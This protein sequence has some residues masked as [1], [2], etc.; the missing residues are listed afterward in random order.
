M[1]AI[2][3]RMTRPGIGLPN[4]QQTEED[5]R[6]KTQQQSDIGL[7]TGQ[8][9]EEERQKRWQEWHDANSSKPP[10]DHVVYEA[11]HGP[12][13]ANHPVV[14][15]EQQ[16]MAA[17]PTVNQY[18]QM[19]L[20][21]MNKH[22]IR[23][24]DA[25]DMLDK[26]GIQAPEGTILKPRPPLNSV[27]SAAEP[28]SLMR[29]LSSGGMNHSRSHARYEDYVRNERARANRLKKMKLLHGDVDTVLTEEEWLEDQGQRKPT[30]SE[31]LEAAL[32]AHKKNRERDREYEAAHGGR[33]WTED[34]LDRN[35][36]NARRQFRMRMA[37]K[38]AGQIA[39]NPSLLTDIMAEYDAGVTNKG[40]LTSGR[41]STHHL[42]G[43][44]GA[45]EM[46]DTL[47]SM[48]LA[49]RQKNVENRADQINQGR[50][51]GVPRGF[52]AAQESINDAMAMGD[53]ARASALAATYSRIYGAPFMMWSGQTN[54]RLGTEAQARAEVLARRPVKDPTPFEQLSEDNAMIAEMPAGPNR[55][56]AIRM[57]AANMTGEGAS[58][59]AI[60]DQVN[61]TYQ[62]F[63]QDLVTNKPVGEWTPEER[64]EFSSVVADMDYAEF[65]AYL[66]LPDDNNS[67]G[68]YK[69]ITGRGSTWKRFFGFGD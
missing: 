22:G 6:K 18:E 28:G 49:Q 59:E 15:P 30:T 67:A 32:E 61:S 51:H 40:V 14:K 7:P 16:G 60:K 41:E 58:Q 64:S 38:Y 33:S 1:S 62:P 46:T 68:L 9:D 35:T 65:I 69:S 55:I 63:A 36:D 13:R 10:L 8:Q 26:Q 20:D 31:N 50:M 45:R 42:G 12:P 34:N 17:P 44:Q 3:R 23:M 47:D 52:I 24:A 56:N 48:D 29:D 4:P 37:K 54:Q 25:R 5:R 21:L 57:Q 11:G 43:V 2:L 27:A 66:G 53:P 19:G 39:Q